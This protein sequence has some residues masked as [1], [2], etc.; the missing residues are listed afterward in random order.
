MESIEL[1]LSS[2]VQVMV[3]LNLGWSGANLH[4]FSLREE[5]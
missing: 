5:F 1:A 4:F 2:V 3:E